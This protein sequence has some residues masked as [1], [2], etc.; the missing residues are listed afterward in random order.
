MPSLQFGVATS[1]GARE[2]M[3]D[4]H[5][6]HVDVRNK[7][8]LFGVFDGHGGVAA[9]QFCA[10]HLHSE[11]AARI[12]APEADLVQA[13]TGGFLQIDRC[14]QADYERSRRAFVKEKGGEG[15]AEEEE[16]DSAAGSTA[17][18]AHACRPPSSQ[19]GGWQCWGFARHSVEEREGDRSSTVSRPG[20]S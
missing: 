19:G 13:F 9:T 7:T 11:I 5:T 8:G 15:D 3:E 14:L 4:F 1:F 10:H 12:E 16:E 20:G 18:L 17:V 2:Y 6:T